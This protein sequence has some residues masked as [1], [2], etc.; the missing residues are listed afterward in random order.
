[1]C[2]RTALTASPDDL[3]EAFG[4]DE[5]P[6]LAPAYNVPP[7]RPVQVLRV[8]SAG[9]RG[10]R[11]EPLR[12]GLV[13][14][15]AD[16]PKIGSRLTLARVETVLTSRA[17]RESAFKRRCLVA[18]SG[19]YEWRRRGKGLS[20]PF[21]VRR[22]DEKPFALA[23]IW[24]RWVSG[25]GEVVESCAILTQAARPPVDAVHDRMPIV[26]EPQSWNRWLDPALTDPGEV[27]KLLEARSPDFAL[28]EVS[29]YVN[30]PRHDDPG[31]LDA[32]PPAQQSLF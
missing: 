18:V 31:C 29:R 10:R 19:F 30:D 25:D 14:F 5:T 20:V 3:R 23:G 13:P 27:A 2:G 6:E 16:D 24:D 8:A 32:A 26:I 7:S 15:W 9:R 22:P 21:F 28:Y 4:L 12:W 11:L 17:F 1:M